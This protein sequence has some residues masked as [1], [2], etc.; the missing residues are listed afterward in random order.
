MWHQVACR[1]A[2]ITPR[3]RLL[4]RLQTRTGHPQETGAFN[5]TWKIGV[6]HFLCGKL[7]LFPE[8]QTG[9]ACSAREPGSR[10]IFLEARF[11]LYIWNLVFEMCR[12]NRYQIYVNSVTYRSR[13]KITC[14]HFSFLSLI[15]PSI[16]SGFDVSIWRVKQHNSIIAENSLRPGGIK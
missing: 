12:E 5:A 8:W 2:A 3:W 13:G 9:N 1:L 10:A 7:R 6:R 15:L 14:F 16:F 4:W 11:R